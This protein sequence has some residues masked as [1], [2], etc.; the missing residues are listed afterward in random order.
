MPR[1]TSAG[2]IVFKR[3]KEIKYLIL[4]RPP[5]ERFRD[6]WDFPRG[7]IEPG[8]AEQATAEREIREETGLEDLVFMP[9]FRE[10]TFWFYRREGKT[11]YKEAIYFLA[12]TKTSEIKIS[13]EHSD[14]GWFAYE[15]ATQRLTSKNSKV[16]L[17]KANEFLEKQK[18]L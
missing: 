10:K 17:A 5:H 13:S 6:N 18:F 1:E 15:E 3:N 16:I 12:E 7:N 4:H 11:I 2:A 14:Y 8:E 9:G